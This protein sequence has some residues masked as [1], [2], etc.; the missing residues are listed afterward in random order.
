MRSPSRLK[1]ENMEDFINSPTVTHQFTVLAE[2]NIL[3][4]MGDCPELHNALCQQTKLG[5]VRITS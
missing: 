2:K 3:C 1:S 5:R 4:L